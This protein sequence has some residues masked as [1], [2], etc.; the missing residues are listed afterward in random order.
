MFL[1]NT[2]ENTKHSCFPQESEQLDEG[3]SSDG[4]GSGSNSSSSGSNGGSPGPVTRPQGPPSNRAIQTGKA[5]TAPRIRGHV[6]RR[7]AAKEGRLHNGSHRTADAAPAST[8]RTGGRSGERVK[9][10]RQTGH[11]HQY[12]TTT[13]RVVAVVVA[14]KGWSAKLGTSGASMV[15]C[16]I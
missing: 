10:P 5:P 2:A 16:L 7:G 9:D 11:R 6:E 1:A 12:N 3:S 15:A 8:C 4:C 14:T 13:N